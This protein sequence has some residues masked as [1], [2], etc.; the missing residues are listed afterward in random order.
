LKEIPSKGRRLQSSREFEDRLAF[1]AG[2]DYRSSSA[3]SRSLTLEAYCV[4]RKDGTREGDRRPYGDDTPPAPA[5]AVPPSTR[6]HARTM[7]SRNTN[8]RIRKHARA[9]EAEQVSEWG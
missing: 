5:P 6:T 7:H 2:S 4:N 3:P 1:R 8:K 9:T